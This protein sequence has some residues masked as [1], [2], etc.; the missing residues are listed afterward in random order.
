MLS[1]R[2]GLAKESIREGR[3]INLAS[4]DK[5]LLLRGQCSGRIF[6]VLRCNSDLFTHSFGHRAALL[7]VDSLALATW[8]ILKKKQDSCEMKE[9]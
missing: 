5:N 2:G 3:A 9:H 4:L 8:N 7:G 6:E 1:L